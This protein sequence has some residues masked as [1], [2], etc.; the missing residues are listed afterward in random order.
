MKKKNILIIGGSGYVGSKLIDVL[1]KIKKYNIINYDLDLYGSNHLPKKK[2]THIYGDVRNIKKIK[3]ILIKFQPYEIVHL[4][5]ISNDP[6][7]LLNKKL[8]KEVNYLS[9]KKLIKVC[10][11]SSIKK[12]LFI[13]TCSVYGI[14]KKKNITE[15]HPLKPITL[16][17]KYKAMCEKIL[18]NR[19][20]KNFSTCIIRPATVCGV[21]PKMR[22]DLSVNILTNFAFNKGFIKVFGGNQR[23]PNIHI[24]EIVRLYIK[25]INKKDYMN[26]NN[27]CFNA[28]GENLSIKNIAKKVKNIVENFQKKKIKIIYEKS[29]DIRSYHVN[30]NKIKKHFDFS[31]KKKID[32]AVLDICKFL[33]TYKRKDTF[34]N[35][36]YYN[37]KKLLSI[38]KLY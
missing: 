25:L 14:S 16:Y 31:P 3:K 37:V 30:S 13:S 22:F 23:R 11:I 29:D 34:T 5:C 10:E 7:F 26:I 8:S 27:Q 33:S 2:I 17:N 38:K 21:S 35:K 9:F 36:N 20:S 24:D 12:F 18:I 6:S 4:A 19:K 15:D 32:D 1:L 28:G